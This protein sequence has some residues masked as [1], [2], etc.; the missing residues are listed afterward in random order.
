MSSF[1]GIGIPRKVVEWPP[2]AETAQ[3]TA[4]ERL[5]AP[6]TGTELSTGTAAVGPVPTELMAKV[7]IAAAVLA[8]GAFLVHKTIRSL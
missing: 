3:P 8:A 6:W 1:T 5:A 2:I 4:A 7:A